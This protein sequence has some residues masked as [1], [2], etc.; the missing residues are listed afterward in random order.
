MNIFLATN[1]CQGTAATEKTLVNAICFPYSV[2]NG[3]PSMMDNH[4]LLLTSCSL[5]T[6][7]KY[8]NTQ[9]ECVSV[10]NRS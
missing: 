10:F 7:N 8:P 1:L 9:T 3:L 4:Y 5:F 6:N 2:I